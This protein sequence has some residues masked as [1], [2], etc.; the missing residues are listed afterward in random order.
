MSEHA[1]SHLIGIKGFEAS[2]NVKYSTYPAFVF[3][4]D[5]L[6]APKPSD[7][8]LTI[9]EQISAKVD[10]YK[11]G[12]Q[13]SVDATADAVKAAGEAKRAASDADQAAENANAVAKEVSDK[14]AAGEF[15]G[16]PGQDGTPGQDGAQG[17]SGVL[18]PSAGMFVLELD[19]ATGDLYAVYPSGENPPQFEYNE[20]S[21]ELYY[22]INGEGEG[23]GTVHPGTG[24]EIELRNN[25]THI[26]WR[27][28][29]SE[30]WTDLVDL[31]ELR[32][33]A[34]ETP[35]FIQRNGHLYAVYQ[36]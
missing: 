22:V 30:T 8:E 36:N 24:R 29:D 13:L 27:Y 20:E 28:T 4:E 18:A 21:G 33:P 1:G 2:G 34:G 35:S 3:V 12:Y 5:W 14:L 26:Q 25:G 10:Q 6:D 32:G 7:K 15:I 11:E 16:P 9:I 31:E 19:P 23:G 17:P